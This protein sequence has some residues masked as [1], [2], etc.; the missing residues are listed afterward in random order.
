MAQRKQLTWA[1]LRVGLFVVVGLL[2]LAVGIFYVT[3]ANF[4]GPK[5]RLKTF[6][7]EVSDLAIGAP[8]RVDGVEVGN[9][10]SIRLVPRTPGHVPDKN[11]NIEV[12]MRID[13]RFQSDIL[14]DSTASLVTDGMLGNLVVNITSG[15]TGVPT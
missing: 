1:E 10:E 5:Y 3:G 14:T 2:V 4:I 9:V 8:V 15:F 13:R 11:K 12:V 7:P 6:L